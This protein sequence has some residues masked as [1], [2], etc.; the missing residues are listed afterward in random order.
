MRKLIRRSILACT[1]FLAAS[2]GD[3]RLIVDPAL[4]PYLDSFLELLPDNSRLYKGI[5]LQF[6]GD[7]GPGSSPNTTKIGICY[8]S[9]RGKPVI[10][11]DKQDFYSLNEEVKNT[12]ILHELGHC[13][14][15]RG[16]T[17]RFL[18]DNCPISLMNPIVV[19]KNCWNTHK[20][21]YINELMKGLYYVR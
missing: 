16:H 8:Y 7:L 2:C 13:A 17:N 1:G 19:N 14:L 9:S 10:L 20:E 15:G 5:S 3:D 11:I 21:Y 4:E 6:T 18:S 12:L